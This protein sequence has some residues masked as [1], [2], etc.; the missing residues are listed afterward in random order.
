MYVFL[1]L[2]SFIQW[3]IIII[4]FRP[5]LYEYI[6][7]IRC[8][9]MRYWNELFVLN[10]PESPL[11]K[12]E[13]RFAIMKEFHRTKE[14]DWLR[15]RMYVC[16]VHVARNERWN[17]ENPYPTLNGKKE[18]T[19]VARREERQE[20]A[21]TIYSMKYYLLLRKIEK[22]SVFPLAGSVLLF[23]LHH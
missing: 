15:A 17:E 19:K 23:E 8:D 16:S 12:D 14:K 5:L 20:I 13:K 21:M 2:F 9:A 7:I 3:I 1:W 18:S 10:A 22:M 11:L 4:S 6:F